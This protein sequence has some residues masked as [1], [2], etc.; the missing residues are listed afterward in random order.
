MSVHLA[1]CLPLSIGL[2]DPLHES[3][4]ERRQILIGEVCLDCL[5]DEPHRRLLNVFAVRQ[6]AE[7]LFLELAHCVLS[8]STVGGGWI[9]IANPLLS[10]HRPSA[11]AMS[12]SRRAS[13]QLSSSYVRHVRLLLEDGS[14]RVR[15]EGMSHNDAGLLRSSANSPFTPLTKRSWSASVQSRSDISPISLTSFLYVE[16]QSKKGVW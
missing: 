16:V 7:Q 14:S 4:L 2:V 9:V 3:G 8:L 1:I 12:S 11:Q 13:T 10:F 5:F 6:P 15:L